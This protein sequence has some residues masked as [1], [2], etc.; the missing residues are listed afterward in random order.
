[1][2]SQTLNRRRY[3]FTLIELLV[4][5][6]IIALLIGI[7]LPALSKA[8]RSARR[9][10]DSANI[11]SV[12][13]GLAI[14]SD[15]N[16]G[17]YPLPSRI[18]EANNTIDETQIAGMTV[19]YSGVLDDPELKDNSSNIFSVLIWDQFVA[20]E[21]LFSPSEPSSTFRAD[22]EYQFSEP[23]AITDQARAQNALW[24]PGF[25][26]TPAGS[27]RYSVGKLSYVHM[28]AI[29][30]RRSLWR[31]NFSATQAI[32]GN[33]G[34][35]F[36]AKTDVTDPWELTEDSLY[37]DG[38]ITLQMHGNR[39]KWEGLVGFNDSHVEFVNDAAPETLTFSF[40]EVTP[41]AD[42]TQPDNVFVNENDTDGKMVLN[43]QDLG[44]GGSVNRNAFLALYNQVDIESN[45]A[46]MDD[47]NAN[48]ELSDWG[49]FHD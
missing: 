9:L 15:S 40:T 49:S 13:Q 21:I 7:L 4:V 20:A 32:V 36:Q 17:R 14:F 33:R 30:A 3:G 2:I 11:R 47:T 46:I 19:S 16:K 41:A 8:R 23:S 5:I 43:Q 34:P 1:M 38:S 39:N 24:D 29:G 6:A 35:T 12:I 45:S 18:D 28:P 26:A 37:G 31:N 10:K 44:N 25:V 27:G 22:T 48:G 42:Q